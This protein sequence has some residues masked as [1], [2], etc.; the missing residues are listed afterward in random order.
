MESAR[1]SRKQKLAEADALLAGVNIFVLQQLGLSAPQE[2]N[3]LTFA[4]RRSDVIRDD[5]FNPDYYHSERISS[6][7]TIQSQKKLRC[8]P[9]GVIADFIREAVDVDPTENYIGLAGVKSNT[10]ELAE[11]V[12]QDID[13]KCFSFEQNDVLFARL[14]PYLNKIWRAERRGVCSTEFHVIRVK[15]GQR[16]LPDYLASILRSSVILAQTKHMMTGNTHP[17]LA[18]EDVVNL[19]VPVPDIPIQQTIA[20]EVTRRREQARRLRNAAN[21]EWEAAKA[22]FE[23]QLLGAGRA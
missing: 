23:A 1:T 16:V 10:G 6:L 13:G 9:L 4:V 11:M 17:R 22:R 5:T 7:R 20:A 14:R 3:R 21:T 8:A 18:N 15:Q 19:V 12:E 2:E